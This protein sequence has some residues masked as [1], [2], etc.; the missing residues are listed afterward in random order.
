MEAITNDITEVEKELA[1][2][3]TAEELLPH[4]EKAYQR[5]QAKIEIKGFRKGKAPLELIKKM[6]G[7]QI[8]YEALDDVATAVY[9][10]VAKEKNIQPVGEP[11]LTDV[12]YKRGE[13]FSFKIKYEVLPTIHLKDY[14]DIAVE[15]PVH[16]VTDAEVEEEILRIRRAN[17]TMVDVDTVTDDEHVVT[18]DIQ[19]LDDSGFPIIGKKSLNQRF[20]LAD[21]T[22]IPEVKSALLSARKETPVRVKYESQHGDHTHNVHFEATIKKIERVQLPEVDDAFVKTITKEKVGTVVEFKEKLRQDIE[23]YWKERSERRVMD[24]IASEI[25]RRHDFQVP[26]ALV[27]NIITRQIEDLKSRFPQ[28]RPPIDFDEAKYREDLRPSAIFQAKWFLLRERI[29]EKEGLDVDDAEL[30]RLAEE[31]SQQTGIEKDKLTEFFKK[32]EETRRQILSDKLITFLKSHAK[33]TEKVT[34]ELF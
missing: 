21:Q 22:L 14:T 2:Q 12:H 33:I 27:N 17:A 34:E 31:R 9:R 30:E 11:V 13:T 6:Y 28:K 5:M 16:T 32:S 4:F 20:Y 15:K 3:L 24:A 29:I 26:E 23:E 1:V 18:A 7:E 8:E 19:E 25:V 10:D